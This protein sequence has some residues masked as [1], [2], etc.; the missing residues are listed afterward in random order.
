L[1]CCDCTKDKKANQR[2]QNRQNYDRPKADARHDKRSAKKHPQDKIGRA[3]KDENYKKPAAKKT[4]KM[5]REKG[6]ATSGS[7]KNIKNSD[8]GEQLTTDYPTKLNALE[9]SSTNKNHDKSSKTDYT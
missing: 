4:E 5:E 1:S 8:S 2:R 9:S 3:K 6:T 7:V